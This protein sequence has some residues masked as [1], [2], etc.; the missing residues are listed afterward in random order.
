MLAIWGLAWGGDGT[1]FATD[2]LTDAVMRIDVARG[3]VE[4]IAGARRFGFAGWL[5]GIGE[6]ARFTDPRGIAYDPSRRVLYV[7]DYA[8]LT[9]RR[10]DLATRVVKTYAGRLARLAHEDG[11]LDSATFRGTEAIVVE[12]E[13]SLLVADDGAVRRIDVVHRTVTTLAGLP[14][15]PGDLDGA[16]SVVRFTSPQGLARLGPTALAVADCGNSAVRR[17]DVASGGVDKLAGAGRGFEDGFG[18]EARFECP[19]GVVYDGAGNLFIADRDNHAVRM[20]ELRS[21]RVST[22]GG[23][24]SR[25][26]NTDGPPKTALFCAPVGVAF[27]AGALFVADASA[28]TIRKIDLATQMVSTLA[29]APFEPGAVDGTGAGARFS[30]PESLVYHPSGKLF[31]ADKENHAV[32]SIDVATGEVKT[33]AG[34]LGHPGTED[35]DAPRF[36]LPRSVALQGEGQLLVIDRASIRVVSLAGGR[37]ESVLRYP[38]GAGVRLGSPP[39]ALNAPWAALPL[40]PDDILLLDKSENSLLRVRLEYGGP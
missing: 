2:A 12:G 26:G 36:E 35:G 9:I 27:G 1:L 23:S 22:L 32:R 6:K 7:S 24:P 8:N 33:F 14:P 28:R 10:I 4:T 19:A 20:L 40:A 30:S 25:C 21:R 37:A 13:N 38:P 15:H 39:A 3:D 31:V 11:A 34:V 16:G 29:G 5:D 17:V 18:L